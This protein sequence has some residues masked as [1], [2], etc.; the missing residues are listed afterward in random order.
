LSQVW[1]FRDFSRCSGCRLCEVACS[2]KHEGV[3]W[4]EAS[5]VKVFEF[6]PGVLVPHLCLQCPDYPCVKA[7][8]T[9]ALSV[10][11]RTGAVLVDEGKCTLCGNCI[12]ACPA[13]VPRV[14]K[15]K[16]YVVICDLC[17]GDPECVKACKSAGFNALELIPRPERAY[18]EPYISLPEVIARKVGERVFNEFVKEVM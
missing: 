3:I 2:L 7:C 14:V 11:P 13:K 6:A 9:N 1:V 12:K 15:G 8:P 4:P 18:M 17:G 16:R 10:D 5:R